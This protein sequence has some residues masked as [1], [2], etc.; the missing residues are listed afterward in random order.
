MSLQ[1]VGH[2]IDVGLAADA[3]SCRRTAG[4]LAGLS[5]AFDQAATVLGR[6]AAVDET[7][8]G[9][10]SGIVYRHSSTLLWH[11]CERTARRS[12]RLAEGLTAYA[13]GMAEVRRL[14]DEAVTVAAPHLRVAEDRIWRPTLPPGPDDTRLAQAWA[15]WRDAVDRWRAARDLEERTSQAWLVALDRG[16]TIDGAVP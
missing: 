12:R 3:A 7:A 4:Q 9:G 5:S 15:A 2:S 6:H 16:V 8:F 1:A 10:L 11:G 14:L 13:Q